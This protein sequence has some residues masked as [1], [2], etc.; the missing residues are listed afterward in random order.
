MVGGGRWTALCAG[1]LGAASAAIRLPPTFSAPFW[2][3]EVA[4]IR[5]VSE[6]GFGAMLRHVA[7][8]ESTP[9]LWYSLAWALRRAGVSFIDLRLLSV[10]A[11]GLL[12]A[13]VYVITSRF[14]PGRYAAIAAGLVAVGSE[15][16][17]QGRWL[18]A[19]EL[20]AALAVALYGALV[21]AWRQPSTRRLAILAGITA[22]GSLTHY[23]FC[24]LVAAAGIWVWL[25]PE[26]R[27][28]RVRLAAAL[29]LGLAPLSAWAPE[30]L[31]Q[32]RQQ[33]FSWIGPFRF[34][35]VLTTPLRLFS[36]FG[37]G[38]WE[39]LVGIAILLFGAYGASRLW[40]RGGGGGRLIVVLWVAPL[41]LAAIVWAAGID[42]YAVRN[43][44]GIGPFFVASFVAGL[45]ALPRRSAEIVAVAVVTAAGAGFVSSARHHGPAYNT[46]ARLLVAQGWRAG[47]TIAVF[48][49]ASE[50]RSPLEWYLPGRPSLVR[51]LPSTGRV[52][53]VIG[54]NRTLRTLGVRTTAHVRSLFVGRLAM[55]LPASADELKRA[56]V[57]LTAPSPS[58]RE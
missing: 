1:A 48:G 28:A 56:S 2:Q 27:P 26:A 10:L 43:M 37:L 32:F 9:P 7:R 14:L 19:Y 5:V 50:F 49:N 8:T 51:G 55:S 35:L 52:R 46:L 33:R 11:N 42:I 3:D 22:A 30:L 57:F 34:E 38:P 47:E 45:A 15:F 54:G 36:S 17:G 40:R 39:P 44:I 41:C 20:A 16:S 12:V 29:A 24:F 23:F 18:R 4:S 53:F 31:A 6:S 58:R 25:E 13:G 21:A